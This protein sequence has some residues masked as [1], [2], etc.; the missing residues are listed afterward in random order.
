[1][2]K[3]GKQLNFVSMAQRKTSGT[4]SKGHEAVVTSQEKRFPTDEKVLSTGQTRMRS[5][6]L[7]LCEKAMSAHTGLTGA[8]SGP[9]GALLFPG[10]Y[11]FF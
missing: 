2:P 10:F 4:V 7:F 9:K 1:M 11:L 6:T 3:K 8:P 5:T